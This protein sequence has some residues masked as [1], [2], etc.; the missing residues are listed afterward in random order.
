MATEI[1]NTP[2][3]AKE[4]A[5]KMEAQKIIKDA[6]AKLSINENLHLTTVQGN[7]TEGANWDKGEQVFE[8]G[9]R[10]PMGSR[11]TEYSSKVQPEIVVAIADQL[12]VNNGTFYEIK[13][14][15]IKS[16]R[17][18]P[19]N[20][21]NLILV[22]KVYDSDTVSSRFIDKEGNS[23]GRGGGIITEVDL[24]KIKPGS[25]EFETNP[26]LEKVVSE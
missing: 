21:E 18:R 3:E 4:E 20:D 26:N 1:D 10:I 8:S 24:Q 11:Q 5:L 23:L 14:S 7:E 16:H 25:I 12:E 13:K 6:L 9:T 17:V 19:T 22:E 15:G 2:E